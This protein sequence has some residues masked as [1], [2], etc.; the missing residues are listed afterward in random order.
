MAV[1]EREIV[2]DM[3][4]SI[5]KGAMSH[6]VLKDGLDNLLYLEKT[7]RAFISR[8]FEGSIEKRIYIDYVIGLFSKTP[9]K[10]MK[11]LI[12]SILRLSVYQLLFMD[13]VPDSA[14][15][16]EAVKLAKKR[17]FT[18]LSGFV[19]GILRTISRQKNE[20]PLPDREK[21]KE[22]YC[23]IKFSIPESLV[24]RFFKDYGD[25]A[26]EIL[27]AFGEERDISIRINE[28]KTDRESLLKKLKEEGVVAK[29]S[30]LT[31]AIKIEKLDSFSFLSSFEEG[32]FWIQDESSQLVSEIAGI[33]GDEVIF[34]LCAAPGGKSMAFATSCKNGGR[35]FSFDLTDYKL[36][37]IDDNIERLG[38]KNIETSLND[39]LVFNE[40]LIEGADV[41][42]C[43][44]PCSGLGVMGRKKDIRFHVTE[45]QIK[46]LAEIQKKMLLNA[47]KY[48]K[49]GGILIFSTCTMTKEENEENFLFLKDREELEVLG[50]QEL[51]PESFLKLRA[52]NRYKDEAKK[53]YLRILPQD[54]N[55]DGF[56][57]SKFIRKK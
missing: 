23:S 52:Y 26:E 49:V 8:L 46:E 6:R 9:I 5:E 4:I 20:I 22:K 41:I 55:S 21:E 11:P 27:S 57:I 51:I 1:N 10:K 37:L 56:F 36:S 14:T 28:V 43:D 38:I 24:R 2:L 7:N 54:F 17:G 33:R 45:E 32:D 3:L 35:V 19:N 50:F 25:E 42:L 31:K 39:A 29:P 48:L 44:L 47:I 16:N 30:L 13:R 15:I 18:P 40:T 34:D 12:I 53:G